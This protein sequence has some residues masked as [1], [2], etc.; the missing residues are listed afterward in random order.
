MKKGVL[1][2]SD[3]GGN[4]YSH[5]YGNQFLCTKDYVTPPNPLTPCTYNLHEKLKLPIHPRLIFFFYV[6]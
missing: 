1:F 6:T 4:F 3:D 5:V 2:P